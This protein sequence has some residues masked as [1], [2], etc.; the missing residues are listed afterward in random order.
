MQ[1]YLENG[2]VPEA[3]LRDA[4]HVALATVHEV[5]YL[6]TWNCRHIANAFIIRKIMTLN[7]KLGLGM[8]II[9]TPE[10]LMEE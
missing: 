5:N 8:P 6:V 10:E 2:V 3:Y 1:L 7:N 9:C 4:A